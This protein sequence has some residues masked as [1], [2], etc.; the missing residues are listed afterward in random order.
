MATFLVA[1]FYYTVVRPGAPFRFASDRS[2]L[3]TRGPKCSVR[4]FTTLATLPNPHLTPSSHPTPWGRRPREG[5]AHARTAAGC[6]ALDV[7]WWQPTSDGLQ[8]SESRMFGVS[9]VF[10]ESLGGW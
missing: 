5:T 4:S 10:A 1:S 9:M 8:P 3:E 2:G 7:L 6:G